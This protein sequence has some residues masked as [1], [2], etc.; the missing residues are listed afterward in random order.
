MYALPM[1]SGA[2]SGMKR[3]KCGYTQILAAKNQAKLIAKIE[4]AELTAKTIKYRRPPTIIIYTQ[5]I[6]LH[7]N[8][9]AHE[10]FTPMK[11][12]RPWNICV[13]EISA[14]MKYLRPWNIC[15]PEISASMKYLRPHEISAPRQECS[16][17]IIYDSNKATVEISAAYKRCWR[18]QM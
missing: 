10:I 8:I 3:I 7:Q 13:H 5:N 9:R 14:P 12:S 6:C 17:L 1:L 18:P 4:L 15:A 11:Y 16:R 2:N